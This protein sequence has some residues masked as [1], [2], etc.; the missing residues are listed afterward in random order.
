[1]ARPALE[2]ADIV[3]SHGAAWRKA[4]SGHV[5]RDQLKVMSAIE[6]CR[7]A[8]LGGHVMRCRSPL[9]VEQLLRDG[10]L[11]VTV[12][13]PTLVQGLNL[14]ATAVI[15][16]GIV[17]NRQPIDVAEF[18]NVVGRAGRAFVDVEGLVLF[19]FFAPHG[20]RQAEWEALKAGDAGR[21]METL[22]PRP[23]RARF[24]PDSG[25]IAAPRRTAG[26]GPA[27]VKTHTSEKCRKY[28]SPTWHSIVC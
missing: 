12:S 27:C 5:S 3:R 6:S 20:L 13:S 18:R 24:S 17:R 7:T 10:V 21:E 28:N 19:P 14:S 26:L 1:M 15:L 23:P 9:E 11:K 8:A 25:R 16:H 4:N 2:L 22:E